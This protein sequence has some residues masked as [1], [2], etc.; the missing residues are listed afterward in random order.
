M[1]SCLCSFFLSLSAS[2][3]MGFPIQGMIHVWFFETNFVSVLVPISFQNTYKVERFARTLCR[4]SFRSAAACCK[5]NSIMHELFPNPLFWM[6]IHTYSNLGFPGWMVNYCPSN[7]LIHCAVT[8][9]RTDMVTCQR[10]FSSSHVQKCWP[11]TT[12]KAL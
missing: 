5:L 4:S 3:P 10:I 12:S 8:L 11:G 9:Q 2:G 7:K 6:C 1:A